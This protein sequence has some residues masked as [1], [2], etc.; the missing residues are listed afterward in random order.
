MA[1]LVLLEATAK[2]ECVSAMKDFFMEHFPETRAYDGCRGITA[3]MNADDSRTFVLVE[4]WNTKDDFQK[5]VAWRI[6][7]GGVAQ[8]ASLLEGTPN[9]RYFETVAA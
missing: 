7:T 6:E 8:L 3:H 5:Y 9:V 2:A 4:H 1:I